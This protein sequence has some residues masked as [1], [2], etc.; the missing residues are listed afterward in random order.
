[1]AAKICYRLVNIFI[2]RLR[3]TNEQSRDAI[4]WGLEATGYSSGSQSLFGRKST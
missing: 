2:Q 4:R 1:M 3:V